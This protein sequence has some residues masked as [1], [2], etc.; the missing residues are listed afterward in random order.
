LVIIGNNAIGPLTDA[1]DGNYLNGSS[2]NSGSGGTLSSMSVHVG[3]VGAAPN[4]KFQMAVYSNVGGPGN[5]IAATGIGS[6]TGLAWNTLPITAT[7][8]ANTTYWLIYNTNASSGSLNNMTYKDGGLSGYSNPINFGAMPASFGPSSTGSGTFDIYGTYGTS[9]PSPSP[10]PTASPSPSP[11][12]APPTAPGPLQTIVGASTIEVNDGTTFAAIFDRSQGGG[13][14]RLYDLTRDPNRANNLGPQPGYTVFNSYLF[15]AGA[16]TW[17]LIGSGSA[18]TF[19][20]TSQSAESTTIHVITPYHCEADPPGGACLLNDVTAESWTTIYPGGYVFFE[21][22]II[23]GASAHSLQNA[24]PASVDLCLCTS[25]NGIFDGAGSDTSYPSPFDVHAG[26]GSEL[27][28]GQYQNPTGSGASLGVLQS[29]YQDN[30]F[31]MK[32]TDMRLIV[33]SAYLR[34]HVTPRTES[35]STLQAN[36]TYLA[37]YRGWLSELANSANAIAIT[38]DYRQPA[39]TVT[40][41]SL[42]ANDSELGASGLVSGYNPGTGRYVVAPNSGGQVDAMLGFPAGVTIRYR[43]S[44]KVVGWNGGPLVV[45]W[46]G[47]VLTPGVD[48]RSSTDSSGALRVSLEY[49]V[50]AGQAV[51]GQRQNAILGLSNT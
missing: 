43:P 27:W 50:V 31:G 18:T 45:R 24:A 33:G 15:N 30:S 16:A 11:S 8:A 9:N 3:A 6:L 40:A 41:G 19:A 14:S 23:T 51:A 35:T 22:R 38:A 25:L 46:G 2:F 26:N 36:T 10:S 17:G 37:R 44:F 28:W 21:R 13:I 5:L 47:A 39:L 7:L 12:P 48:Y 1:Y 42:Q 29:A 4:N 49:D 20:V 34:S 32:F